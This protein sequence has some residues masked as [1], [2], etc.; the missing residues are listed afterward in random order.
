MV[1]KELKG[2]L[3]QQY[4]DSLVLNVSNQQVFLNHQTIKT[5]KL[6]LVDVEK[7]AAD[8]ILSIDGISETYIA[9]DMKRF[10][11]TNNSFKALLQNGYN[12]K[13]SGDVMFRFNVAYFEAYMKKG[14]T[15]GAE[16]SYDTHVPLLFYGWGIKP[17]SS[18][19]S[20]M[21]TDIAPTICSLLN[22]PFP[23]GCTGKPIK[24]VLDK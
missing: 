19:E 11:Y 10:S 13:R 6:E 20:I 5:K 14:T 7:K 24:A 1:E 23:N 22:I 18:V 8:F 12:F 4:G 3:F 2:Y 21:I 17:G 15:H 16:F 9:D